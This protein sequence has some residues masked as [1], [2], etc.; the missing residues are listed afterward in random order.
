[1]NK[2]DI[3][4]QSSMETLLEEMIRFK[5]GVTSDRL[6]QVTKEWAG[7]SDEEKDP[8][9]AVEGAPPKRLWS[10]QDTWEFEG[11]LSKLRAG[12]FRCTNKQWY[13]KGHVAVREPH[14]APKVDPRQVRMDW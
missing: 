3:M 12:D 6:F 9:P 4:R 5:P 7:C 10:V 11:T 1:M 8:A 2:K 14:G 13:P